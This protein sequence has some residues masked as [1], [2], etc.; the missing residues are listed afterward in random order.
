M[1]KIHILPPNEALKIAAGEVIERPSHVIK[2]LIENALD[3][4]A[5]AISLF[6]EQ[7]GKALIRIVDNGCGMSDEDAQRC[8]LP[9]ATSKIQSLHDLEQIGSFGFRGEALASIAAISLVTLTT[10]TSDVSDADLGVC[11]EYSEGKLLR[12][13]SIACKQGT[14]IAVRDLFYNTP[15]RKKFLKQDETEW[16]AIQS[17]IHAFCLSNPSVAFK[18]YHD[19]KMILNAPAVT[20][21]LDRATQIW[22]FAVAQHLIPLAEESMGGDRQ[23]FRISGLIS[24]HQLWRYGRN[25]MHFFVNKRWVRNTELGKAVMKGY[26][27]V[28]PPERF[29]AALI[30]I[31]V[32]PLCVDVNVHPKKEE[33]RFAKSVSVP[34]SLTMLI[35]KTLEQ[36]VSSRVTAGMRTIG[37]TAYA[38]LP[39]V[40]APYVAYHQLP[41][42]ASTPADA[43]DIDVEA[44]FADVAAS[45]A[46]SIQQPIAPMAYS[47]STETN[48]NLPLSVQE[49]KIIGQLFNTYIILENGES[50]VIIDQHAAHERVL[51][52][53]FKRQTLALQGTTLIFPEL[54]NVEPTAYQHLL[55]IQKFLVNQGIAF[56]LLASNQIAVRSCPPQLKGSS[57]KEFIVELASFAQEYE[58]LDPADFGNRL[59]EHMHAQLACKSAVK[60]GDPL[61]VEQMRQLITDLEVSENRFICVHG[62]PTTWRI[63]KTQVEKQFKRT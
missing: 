13:T 25:L 51:Y 53:K 60:A 39:S 3:A 12:Q 22:D 47:K 8:F 62:R 17:I 30:F 40:G 52:E 35:K 23:P 10:K 44:L 45:S 32:D 28:L 5:S 24:N 36:E 21:Y 16:N 54:I 43:A 41:P 15:V 55:A 61:T 49:P 20:G 26:R 58:N 14:D 56:D 33:V 37:P 42:L 6:I 29:P 1:T 7:S 4:Q 46:F 18:L 57:L 31:D 34:A 27:D 50:L 9:H 63:A 19:N 59:H 11:I 38:S 48:A 2:E